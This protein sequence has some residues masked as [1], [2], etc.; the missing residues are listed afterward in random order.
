MLNGARLNEAEAGYEQRLWEAHVRGERPPAR[1]PRD[2]WRREVI[3]RGVIR[4]PTAYD[5]YFMHPDHRPSTHGPGARYVT[6]ISAAERMGRPDLAAV[7]EEEFE[8]FLSAP[9]P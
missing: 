9:V 2:E 4:D 8:R 3:G 1:H 6:R 7:A 5:F